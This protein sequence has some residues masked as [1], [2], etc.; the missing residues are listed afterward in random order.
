MKALVFEQVGHPK[1]VLQIKE[2]PKPEVGSGKVLIKLIASPINPSD[3]MFIRGLYGI[4]AQLPAIAGFEGYG[5]I[6]AVGQ[7]VGLPVGSPAAFVNLGTWAEYVAVPAHN[8][9]PLPAT[10]PFEV[11]AQIFVNPFT[12]WAMLYESGLQA[13]EWLLLTGGSSTFA[14]LVIQMASRKG[15]NVICAVRREGYEDFLLGLGAK[16]VINTEKESLPE[17]VTSITKGAMVD[18]CFDATGGTVASLAL[19]SLKNKG[20]MIVYGMMSLKETPVNNGLLIFKG[21]TIRGFWL[22]Q[23][24][25]ETA[26]SLRQ[27]AAY[28]IIT[29]FQSGMLKVQVTGTFPLEQVNQAIEAFEREGRS[30]KILLVNC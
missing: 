21:L 14:Q 29:S 16:A 6:E 24:M 10:I 19:R 25:S 23:W 2:L 20:K 18:C 17:Q 22:S 3:L 26:P 13:E 28:E 5:I 8:V 30:G 12:A 1:E 11:G 4:Q 15:I 9:M 7:G 27:Q